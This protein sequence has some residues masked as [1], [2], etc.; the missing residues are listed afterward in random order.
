MTVQEKLD[1]IKVLCDIIS[2][3]PSF[4]KKTVEAAERKLGELIISLNNP[5]Q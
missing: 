4:D 2:N 1:A 3:A 5:N